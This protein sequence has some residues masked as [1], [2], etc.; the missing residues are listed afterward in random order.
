M[1]DNVVLSVVENP[2]GGYDVHYGG[3]TFALTEPIRVDMASI[4]HSSRPRNEDVF[5]SF[6]AVYV[7]PSQSGIPDN[8]ILGDN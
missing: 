2:R 8:I 3:R 4:W 1:S 6:R 7:R 5:F